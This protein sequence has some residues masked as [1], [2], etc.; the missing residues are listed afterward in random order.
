VD[1]IKRQTGKPVLHVESADVTA[2]K[3]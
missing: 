2:G 3:A 1:R